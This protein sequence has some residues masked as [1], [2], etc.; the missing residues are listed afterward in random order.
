MR[1]EMQLRLTSNR[2]CG[3]QEGVGLRSRTS[4]EQGIA[5]DHYEIGGHLPRTL[6]SGG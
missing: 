4:A 5:P 1:V 2:S 3:G 6:S